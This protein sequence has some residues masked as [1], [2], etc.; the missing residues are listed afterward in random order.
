V[1]KAVLSGT[2]RVPTGSGSD[3]ERLLRVGSGRLIVA[4][5]PLSVAGCQLPVASVDCEDVKER[6]AGVALRR[7]LAAWGCARRRRRLAPRR[8]GGNDLLYL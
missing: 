4:S 8:E 3:P 5:C 6:G 2:F 7:R 1:K